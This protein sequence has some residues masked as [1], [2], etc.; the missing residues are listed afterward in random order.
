MNRKIADELLVTA[1]AVEGHLRSAYRKLEIGSRAELAGALA[2][3]GEPRP[4]T[5]AAS[6]R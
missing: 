2:E 1:K 5:A 6:L 4:A 3:D